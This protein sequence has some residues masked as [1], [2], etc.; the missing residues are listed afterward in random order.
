MK[1]TDSEIQE[2]KKL[3]ESPKKIVITTHRSPDGD[4]IGSSLG[5][6]HFLKTKGHDALVIAP[7]KYPEFLRWLPGTEQV[8]IF[9]KDTP[10]AKTHIENADIIFFLDFNAL[11]RIKDMQPVMEQSKAIKILIDHHPLPDDFTD[12]AL[13]D[14][15]A[16]STAELLYEFIVLLGE[17]DHIGLESAECIYTGILTDT[18]SF[19]YSTTTLRTHHIAANLL[20]KGVNVEKVQ[21]NVYDTFSKDRI[22]LLGYCLSEKLQFFPEYHTALI[23]LSLEELKRYNYQLGDTEDIVNFGLSVKGMRLSVFII[24]WSDEIKLSFRSK[25]NF[26]ANELAKQHFEGGGHVNAAGGNSG[27]SLEKTIEKF[28][29]ILPQYKEELRS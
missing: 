29:A 18:G 12:Y 10:E 13:S 9:D 5:L 7:N 17:E 22:G 2:I 25:G 3:L 21:T 26:P 16:S 8:L 19:S 6:Y 28:I 27:L 11:Y 1:L 15:T 23:S 20:K 4:A 24:E 14:K